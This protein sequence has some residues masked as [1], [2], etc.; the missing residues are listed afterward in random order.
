MGFITSICATQT[1]IFTSGN[2]HQVRSW[3]FDDGR[4]IREYNDHKGAVYGIRISSGGEELGQESSSEASSGRRRV[5]FVTFSADCTARL[6]SATRSTSLQTFS[7]HSGPVT[8]VALDE[9]R[10]LLYTGSS[11]GRIASW[12]VETGQNIHWFEGHSAPIIDLLVSRYIACYK[13]L[14]YFSTEQSFNANFSI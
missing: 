10:H 14:S 3:S 1:Q 7:G 6:W 12:L 13:T 11:D 8:C 9:K 4:L 2:D 5:R